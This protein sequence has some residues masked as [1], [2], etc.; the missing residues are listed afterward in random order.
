MFDSNA[1]D[2]NPLAVIHDELG[3]GLRPHDELADAPTAFQKFKDTFAVTLGCGGA[4]TLLC[5]IGYLAVRILK[6]L[7]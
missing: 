4:F 6:L 1:T 3:R 2:H 7:F 5:L